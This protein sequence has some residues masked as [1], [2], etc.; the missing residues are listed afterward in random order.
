MTL[1]RWVFFPLLIFLVSDIY[2]SAMK[3]PPQLFPPPQ[4]LTIK[5]VP[6]SQ[7]QNTTPIISTDAQKSMKNLIAMIVGCE[8]E[9]QCLSNMLTQIIQTDPN[10]IY[11]SMLTFLQGQKEDPACHTAEMVAA[12]KATVAC[13]ADQLNKSNIAGLKQD[14]NNCFKD[15][16]EKLAKEGNIF[17]QSALLNIARKAK[18]D[19]SAGGWN[20]MMQSEVGTPQYDIYLK[21]PSPFELLEQ[22]STL[23]GQTTSTAMPPPPTTLP[24]PKMRTP[25]GQQGMPFPR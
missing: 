24:M 7:F 25:N 21:C 19:Q 3:Q 16:M 6:P 15:R 20:A 11:Q 22:L 2:A 8:L 17:A 10:P 18:D 14:M 4:N 5:K 12:K 23:L 1:L 9:N 13:L